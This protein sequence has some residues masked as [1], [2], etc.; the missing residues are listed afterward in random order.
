MDSYNDPNNVLGIAD[1]LADAD[2]DL[3]IDTIER[4]ITQGI[5]FNKRD[6]KPV[7]IAQEYNR[8]L[9]QLSRQFNVPDTG[10]APRMDDADNLLN[11]DPNEAR[12][13]RKD[14]YG[15]GAVPSKPSYSVEDSEDSEDDDDDD[16]DD[17]DGYS[18]ERSSSRG[19]GYERS[20]S[21][22]RERSPTN[23]HSSRPD[24]QQLNRMT[25]EQRK[26]SHIN[27]VLGDVNDVDGDNQFLEQ[28]DEE[29]EMARILEQIDLLRTNLESEGVDL[30]RIQEVDS[31]TSR[32]EAKRVLRILQ[33]KNDRLRY[34]DMFE[35]GILA[36]AY[37]LESMFDGKKE[38]FG[39]K[40][41]LVG[42]SDTVK[43]KLRRMRYDTSSFVSGVMQ[44]YAIGHG[45]RIVFE[46]LPSL[47]LYSR[48]RRL[49]TNDNLVS[50]S[51]Y[52]DAMRDLG[53][54]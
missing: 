52:K 2:E 49:R 5:N 9:E 25:N 45:W 28:E 10:P 38:W 19:R 23:W 54:V 17:D 12:D 53:N 48:D 15:M 8:E 4:S 7:D 29:D 43:V 31:E 50:D 41:D 36:C 33:I 30:G 35:E 21:R 39:S 37:G 16:D 47:F 32:T 24:D 20:H 46:L 14:D 1:I 18:P 34:C 3:D 6:D 40:I 11:W 13:S 42:Y 27:D 51:S 44:G 26:Q 22:D